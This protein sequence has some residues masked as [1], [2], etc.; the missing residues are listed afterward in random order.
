MLRFW[1]RFIFDRKGE[2][3]LGLGD[4][5]YEESKAEIDDF[6]AHGFED[7]AISFLTEQ[8]LKRAF[9]ILLR[10]YSQLQGRQL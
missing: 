5:L 4:V 7:V 9:K 10:T 8:K 1:Y 2:I 3:A 6:I